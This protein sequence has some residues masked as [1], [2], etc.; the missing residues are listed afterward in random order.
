MMTQCLAKLA[1]LQLLAAVRRRLCPH[2]Q[3]SAASRCS[4]AALQALPPC[5][6]L[7]R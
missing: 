7:L 6:Q 2:Q 1:M 5:L 3:Y 4:A